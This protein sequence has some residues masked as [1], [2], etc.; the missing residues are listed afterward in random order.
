MKYYT[1]TR[2][3]LNPM[4]QMKKMESLASVFRY[5]LSTPLYHHKKNY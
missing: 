5:I 1:S 2:V 3:L 4:L